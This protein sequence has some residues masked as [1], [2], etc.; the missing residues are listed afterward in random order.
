[1]IFSNLEIN[2]MKP[3]EEQQK[4]SKELATLLLPTDEFNEILKGTA[5]AVKDFVVN[6]NIVDIVPMIHAFGAT[7]DDKGVRRHI[8]IQLSIDMQLIGKLESFYL[9]GVKVAQTASPFALIAAFLVNEGTMTP[10]GKNQ[11]NNKTDVL[12]VHGL[13]IDG[14]NNQTVFKVSR[15]SNGVMMLTNERSVYA[16]KDKKSEVFSNLLISFFKGWLS[17]GQKKPEG[18][19]G[20]N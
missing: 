18:K 9:S 20:D 16:E 15:A 6:Q 10:E 5:K 1:M 14:R 17:S 7:K 19:V 3:T 12:L 4:L 11:E 13:T 2:N 8:L